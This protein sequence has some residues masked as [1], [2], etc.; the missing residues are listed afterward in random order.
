[1]N[2]VRIKTIVIS[3]FRFVIRKLRITCR[4]I[5]I[6]RTVR[7]LSYEIDRLKCSQ[8]ELRCQVKE[9]ADLLNY[10]NNNCNDYGKTHQNHS[11]DCP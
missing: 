8:V 3:H 4:T 9:L 5:N 6:F 2:F 1:M 10:G 7:I 11:N